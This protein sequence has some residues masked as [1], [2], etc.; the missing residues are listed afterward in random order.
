MR[1]K[2]GLIPVREHSIPMGRDTLWL[3][4]LNGL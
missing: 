3:V 1:G 2:R 4:L